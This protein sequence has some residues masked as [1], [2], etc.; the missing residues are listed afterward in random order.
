MLPDG[1]EEVG[2]ASHEGPSWPWQEFALDLKI[3]ASHWRVLSKGDAT[4]LHLKKI[5]FV[6]SGEGTGVHR[7]RGRGRESR[8]TT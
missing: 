4:Q 5:F 7:G 1:S 8:E 3:M 6:L 2:G